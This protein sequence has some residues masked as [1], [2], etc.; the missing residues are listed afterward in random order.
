MPAASGAASAAG[1]G[2]VRTRSG[3][4]RT[5]S[6]QPAPGPAR[7]C[8][9][10]EPAA[11][12]ARPPR[13]AAPPDQG[14]RLRAACARSTTSRSR[15]HSPSIAAGAARPARRPARRPPSGRPASTDP[16]PA[17]SA[18]VVTHVPAQ[19]DAGRPRPA[20]RRRCRRSAA[21]GR[22][23]RR[24]RTTWSTVTGSQRP[25]V[26]GPRDV[27]LV[28][29]DHDPVEARRGSPSSPARTRSASRSA[30]TR[31][32]TSVV[33]FVPARSGSSSRLR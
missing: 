4:G 18:V 19:V 15:S 3:S 17:T 8:V 16:S 10:T 25:L 31:A 7:W 6:Q 11:R 23:A 28:Q 21:P 33:V 1:L 22:R 12:S 30:T 20:G 13:P 27:R 29:G 9:T 24:A 26:A 2:D 5:C 32:S 14:C